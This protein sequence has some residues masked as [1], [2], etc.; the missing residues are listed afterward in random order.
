MNAT[1]IKINVKKLWPSRGHLNIDQRNFFIDL[2]INKNPKYCI[3]TGFCTGRSALTILIAAEPEL[4]I[5][6]DK[7][8]QKKYIDIIELNFKN[9]KFIQ[10][11]SKNILTKNFLQKEYPYGIDFA[12]IDGDHS[13]YGCL[14]DLN[15]IYPF[16]NENSVMLIDDYMSGPPNGISIPDVNHAVQD[17]IKNFNLNLDRWYKNGKSF[18]IIKN[19]KNKNNTTG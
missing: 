16:L 17:F 6:I 19:E 7:N 8:R 10:G 5:S 4:L 12:F 1:A 3:E 18:A 9:F 15:T 11:H 13:Y 14:H 2:L